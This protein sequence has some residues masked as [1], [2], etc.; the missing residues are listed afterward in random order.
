MQ[1]QLRSLWSWKIS[2]ENFEIFFATHDPTTINRNDVGHNTEVKFLSQR[3][4]EKDSRRLYWFNDKRGYFGK[5]CN[6]I[7][8]ASKFYEAEDYHQNYYNDNKTQ[9]YC[10]YIITQNRK[11]KK[12]IKINLKNNGERRIEAREILKI[13]I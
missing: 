6:K 8:S 10:S 9:G 1:K 4:A 5:H 7:S 12:V 13:K 3:G 2:F 11:L